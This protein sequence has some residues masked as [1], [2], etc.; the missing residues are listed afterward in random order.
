MLG[1]ARGSAYRHA[2]TGRAI[3][4]RGITM[5]SRKLAAV[6]IAS[7]V[8]G[9]IT[10]ALATAA[11]QSQAS[12]QAIAAAVQRVQD[13]NAERTLATISQRLG[14]MSGTL[15]SA[16]QAINTQGAAISAAVK[17]ESHYQG[18][19]TAAAYNELVAIC[20][21]TTPSPNYGPICPFNAPPSR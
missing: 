1:G 19:D 4:E 3:P 10:G 13:T 16:A 12:P 9:G 18:L 7:G 17:L 8:F 6:A 2:G 20:R 21:N 14:S 11:T 5:E 15:S